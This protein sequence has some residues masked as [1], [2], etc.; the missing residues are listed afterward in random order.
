MTVELL[1]VQFFDKLEG[2]VHDVITILANTD[3][4]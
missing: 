4:Y 1:I 2:C 3:F